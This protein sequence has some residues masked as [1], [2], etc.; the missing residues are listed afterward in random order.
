MFPHIPL[1]RVLWQLTAWAEAGSGSGQGHYLPWQWHNCPG[2]G[3]LSLD[4]KIRDSVESNI[5]QTI[6]ISSTKYQND[7]KIVSMWTGE[8]KFHAWNFQN[9]GDTLVFA[10]HLFLVSNQVSKVH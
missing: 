2:V 3:R 1:A 7:D 8:M 6:T 4:L 5:M 10:T 9:W